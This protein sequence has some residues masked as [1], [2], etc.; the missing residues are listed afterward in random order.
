M[1]NFKTFLNSGELEVI[2]E[3]RVKQTCLK[4]L[5]SHGEFLNILD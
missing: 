3:G 1:V 5:T 2:C 4:Y